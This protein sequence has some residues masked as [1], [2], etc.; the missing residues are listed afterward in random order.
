MESKGGCRV[1]TAGESGGRGGSKGRRR[2][3]IT[4]PWAAQEFAKDADL[5][6]QLMREIIWQ[7]SDDINCIM[8]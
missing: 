7:A 5:L 8:N 6:A 3:S 1:S 4:E 2:R